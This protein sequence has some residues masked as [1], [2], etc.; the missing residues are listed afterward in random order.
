MSLDGRVP[1]VLNS[2]VGPP[3]QGFGDHGPL[4]APL[5]LKR[6][7]F[8]LLFLAERCLVDVGI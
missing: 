8:L 3:R 7:Y 1:V 4:V 6:D 5:L 2:V